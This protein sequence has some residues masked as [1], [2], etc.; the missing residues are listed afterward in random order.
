M[1][2]QRTN[3]DG[4]VLTFV[5]SIAVVLVHTT[6]SAAWEPRREAKSP[7][8]IVQA[9]RGRGLNVKAVPS[10]DLSVESAAGH[11]T[12]GG[13]LSGFELYLFSD[14]TYI[15]TEWADMLRETIFEKGAWNVKDGFIVLKPDGSLP[16]EVS[17]QD[18]RY[19]PLLLDKSTTIYLMSHRWDYSYFLDNTIKRHAPNAEVGDS[20]MF[21]ICTM[22]RVRQLSRAAQEERRRELMS[23]AWRPEF[24]KS[25]PPANPDKKR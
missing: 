5:V 10:S 4:Y 25:S 17:H 20:T 3:K 19:V 13:G 12:H 6:A 15:Y 2:R 1:S 21:G 16:A 9:L 7:D 23:E 11:Y 18:H 24:F 8:E 14:A 22:H